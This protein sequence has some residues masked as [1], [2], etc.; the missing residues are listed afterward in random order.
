GWSDAYNLSDLLQGET[1]GDAANLAD[2]L[3]W[4][5]VTEVLSVSVDG[6]FSGGYNAAQSDLN[7]QID[8]YAGDF[9]NL[10]DNHII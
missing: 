4:D 10:V 2:Y 6:N 5:A 9:N 7:I 3:N 8:N 1:I